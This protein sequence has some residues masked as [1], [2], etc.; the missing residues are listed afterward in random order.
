[1]SEW[2]AGAIDETETWGEDVVNGAAGVGEGD[3]PRDPPNGER[4]ETLDDPPPPP[5]RPPAL[6]QRMTGAVLVD[7]ADEYGFTTRYAIELCRV[8]DIDPYDGSASHLT[9]DEVEMFHQLA[10]A[11]P[12][13]EDE[14]EWQAS[15]SVD[16]SGVAQAWRR[17]KKEI[18]EWQRL[19]PDADEPPPPKEFNRSAA[20]AMVW[21]LAVLVPSLFGFLAGGLLAIIAIAMGIKARIRSRQE[22]NLRGTWLGNLAIAVAV[23][24]LVVLG[25]IVVTSINGS[26]KRTPGQAVVDTF[27]GEETRYFTALK[28]GEC[29]D[30][31][32]DVLLG[33]SEFENVKLASCSGEHDVEVFA[34]LEQFGIADVDEASWPGV[35]PLASFMLPECEA[36]FEGYAGRPF[37]ESDLDVVALFPPES[38]W[39]RGDPILLCGVVS[40]NRLPLTGSLRAG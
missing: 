4:D 22:P 11:N 13:P 27:T 29:F 16:H 36:R 18:G 12:E 6:P 28:V 30:V 15:D 5:A 40:E 33:R 19:E 14:P 37:P 10:R 1:M 8:A 3:L 26:L 2:Q 23:F 32:D 25:G 38:Q 35:D 24:G 34:E 21:A 9:P 7:L 17:N 20:W 39:N 31:S